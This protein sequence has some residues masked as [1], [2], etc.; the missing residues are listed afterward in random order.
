MKKNLF[1]SIR[2]YLIKLPIPFILF[3]IFKDISLKIPFG[4]HTGN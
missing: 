3:H 2:N 4:L 1:K